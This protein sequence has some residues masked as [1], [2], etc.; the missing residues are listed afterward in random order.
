[1]SSNPAF[2][3]CGVADES[4]QVAAAF[5]LFKTDI[6]EVAQQ[7]DSLQAFVGDIVRRSGLH[8]DPDVIG[9]AQ[10]I[11]RLVQ[12]LY[13][14]VDAASAMGM[15]ASG[16]ASEGAA[17]FGQS[18]PPRLPSARAEEPGSLGDVELF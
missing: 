15:A 16:H 17:A 8:N 2:S 4:Y 12:R 5:D 7:T 10:M 11:D 3:A 1:M 18:F 6:L 13:A 14:L 9:N